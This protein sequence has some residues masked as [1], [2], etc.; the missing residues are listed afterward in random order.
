MH[1]FVDQ[2]PAFEAS[3]RHFLRRAFNPRVGNSFLDFHHDRGGQFPSRRGGYNRRL[4]LEALLDSG[5][6]HA[7]NTRIEGNAANPDD[8]GFIHHAVQIQFDL[9]ETMDAQIVLTNSIGQTIKNIAFE[10]ADKMQYTL[11]T[12]DLAEGIYLVNMITEQG[13]ISRK[14][15][16]RH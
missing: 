2:I 14:L 6:I 16:V 11:S 7:E 3:R 10:S 1:V 5:H 8:I 15:V 13:I 4:L 12:N 9:F